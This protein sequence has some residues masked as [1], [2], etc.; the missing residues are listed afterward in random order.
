MPHSSA[1]GLTLRCLGFATTLASTWAQGV[2]IN[3]HFP[4][5]SSGDVDLFALTPDGAEIL[6]LADQETDDVLELF[7]A[8]VD[9][10]SASVRLSAPL[11]AGAEVRAFTWAATR[12][13]QPIVVSPLGDWMAYLTLGEVPGRLRLYGVD[14]DDPSSPILIQQG[15]FPS[16]LLE[17]RI[18]PA[19]Q[20]IVYRAAVVSGAARIRLFSAPLDGS[21]PPVQLN[22]PIDDRDVDGFFLSPDGALAY[23][24]SDD[25]STT[26]QVW[27]RP[28]DASAVPMLVSEPFAGDG[29]VRWFELSPDGTRI[30]YAAEESGVVRLF[31]RP[32]DASAPAVQLNDGDLELSGQEGNIPISPDGT[33]VVYRE[34]EAFGS[35][36]HGLFSVPLDGSSPPVRLN[37]AT[38][39]PD[40]HD[41]WISP[42]S[43]WV[44][45]EGR[46]QDGRDSLYS[47]PLDGSA[48]ATRLHDVLPAFA[49]LLYSGQISADSMRVFYVADALVDGRRDLFGVPIDGS[50]APVRIDPAGQAQTSVHRWFVGSTPAAQHVVF[51]S[52]PEFDEAYELFAA[53]LDGSGPALR[54]TAPPLQFGN[55]LSFEKLALTPDGS[56][57]VYVHDP[58]EA[59]AYEAWSVPLDGSL[60]PR[61][62]SAPLQGGPVLGDVFAYDFAAGGRRLYTSRPTVPGDT[63]IHVAD[64][65][66]VPRVVPL[67]PDPGP[68]YS[69]GLF[70]LSADR[71]TVFFRPTLA[72]GQGHV[73]V[74]PADAS[75]P[76]VD[77]SP[78]GNVTSVLAVSSNDWALCW[79]TDGLLA[80]ASAAGSFLLTSTPVA[81]S[82]QTSG[83][84]VVYLTNEYPFDRQELFTVAASGGFPV[85]LH[86]DM[87]LDST[88][89]TFRITLDG[90]RVL[91]VANDGPGGS[92]QLYRAPI[93]GGSSPVVLNQAGQGV[94]ANLRLTPDGLGVAYQSNVNPYAIYGVA[95]SGGPPIQ[96][97]GPMVSGGLPQSDFEFS[98]G[99]PY[100]VYRADADTNDVTELYSLRIGDPAPVK[101]S[102]A[103]VAGGDVLD[104]RLSPDGSR[105]VYRADQTLDG[106][107]ELYGVAID[108]SL[109]A[110]RLD[111]AHVAGDVV[112]DYALTSSLV[113]YRGNTRN[114]LATELFAVPLDGTHAPRR[115]NGPLVASGNVVSFRIAPEGSSVLY[116]ADQEL[117]EVFELYEATF[118]KPTRRGALR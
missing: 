87:P 97:S 89:F 46:E 62:L 8:P 15:F 71:D 65:G 42:D 81:S 115:L 22:A 3:E 26:T 66:R 48:P 49:T 6:Y 102:G 91:F 57:A 99:T 109:P 113:V 79:R 4:S 43:Q 92:T 32:S 90:L 93:F 12:R 21:A 110:V 94:F 1:F 73:F 38:A 88:V 96:L 61:R 25:T 14:L 52:D 85:P 31:G 60:L 16:S 59:Q 44:V 112:N 34:Y 23:Y 50:H 24:I 114:A 105:V 116:R 111:L 70:L 58:N 51:A 101:L 36:H 72:D 13:T 68:G 20:R 53:P 40:V 18:A 78:P 83:N 41:Y 100:L 54:L 76:P 103:M 39:C 74:A 64:P 47:A 10:S 5:Q 108:G 107:D 86:P 95:I 75:T 82:A 80:R 77:I 19:Q 30:V 63:A 55:S 104:F 29:I 35:D 117:D 33:R 11:P 9:G 106:R 28:I 98:S 45:F 84:R 7:R 17:A 56:R 69:V 67:E 37:S 2:K 118:G 27:R